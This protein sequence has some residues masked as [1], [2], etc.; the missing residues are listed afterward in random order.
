MLSCPFAT[1]G[2]HAYIHT[3]LIVVVGQY[4]FE[5]RIRKVA[6]ELPNI[7]EGLVGVQLCTPFL[8]Q[9]CVTDGIASTTSS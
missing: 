9:I 2:S 4:T 8:L 5:S 7:I 6:L 1:A 3:V